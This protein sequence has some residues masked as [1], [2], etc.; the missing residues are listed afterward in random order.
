MRNYPRILNAFCSA[1]WAIE[2]AKLE[3]MI[4]VLSLRISGG[5]FSAEEIEQRIGAARQPVAV[6]AGGAVAII[7]VFGVISQRMDWFTESSG[8]TSTEGL[9]QTFDEAMANPQV[10]SV[11]LNV[12][13]PGGEV[14]GIQE[15]AQK[16]YKARGKKPIVAVA[17]SMAASG[18]YWI[19]SAADEVV[20]TP[21]GQVGSVGVFATHL[22]RGK[23]EE[24][25]GLK[26]TLISAGKYKV[27]GH[28]HGPLPDEAAQHLQGMVDSY[29]GDFVAALAR[30][31][32]TTA[33]AVKKG[34][35]EGRMLLAA[36]A[37]KAG[38]A[39][40]IATLEQ[41]IRDLSVKPKSGSGAAAERPTHPVGLLRRRMEIEG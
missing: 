6:S 31:R 41:V 19:A 24:A 16:I 34:Y 7:N 11:V 26:Y 39:D 35:G 32:G 18:A 27:E 37:V 15:V 33:T 4:E 14:F 5:R 38:M 25:L 29:Y 40:R 13:S 1:F 36:D 20:V 21:S 12:D 9:A 30:N 23:A 3:A 2:P 17:N 28:P 10:G 8:G 22:D